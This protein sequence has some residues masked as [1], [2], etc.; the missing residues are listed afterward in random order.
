MEPAPVS[1]L[2]TSHVLCERGTSPRGAYDMDLVLELTWLWGG[3]RGRAPGKSD[4]AP[5][6]LARCLVLGGSQVAV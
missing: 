5:F 4:T 3:G 6:S 1:P 2:R